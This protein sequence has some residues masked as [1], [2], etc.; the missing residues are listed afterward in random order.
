MAYL[1]AGRDLPRF[2][3][4][5]GV[6]FV[7]LALVFFG[8][9]RLMRVW[10]ESDRV[11]QEVVQELAIARGLSEEEA[12]KRALK[13]LHNAKLYRIVENPTSEDSLPLRGPR[14]QKF[15]SRFETVR[16][17]KGETSL[18]RNQIGTS[19]LRDGFLKIGTDMEHTEIVARPNEDT[20]YIIDGSEPEDQVLEESFPTIYHYI[21]AGYSARLA[22][23]DKELV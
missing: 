11:H 8:S 13:L 9:V 1:S 7:F 17:I 5:F 14:L 6:S 19:S 18:D 2:A 12:E 22:L 21:A 3:I 16:E 23:D 10:R 15:F 4:V 20:I